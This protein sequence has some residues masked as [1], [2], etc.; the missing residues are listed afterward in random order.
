MTPTPERAL[1]FAKA[2]K[3]SADESRP[4]TWAEREQRIVL[5]ADHAEEIARMLTHYA[6]ILPKW[7]AVLDAEPVATVSYHRFRL[8]EWLV[9]ND[10]VASGTQLIIKPAP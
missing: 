8:L 10:S 7:Q 1:A 6:E 9:S 3:D 4:R 5:L 2:L